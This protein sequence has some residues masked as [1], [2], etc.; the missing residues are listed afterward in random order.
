MDDHGARELVV[1]ALVGGRQENRHIRS[2]EQE[3][4]HEAQRPKEGKEGGQAKD[5]CAHK[6]TSKREGLARRGIDHP[7][8]HDVVAQGA[9][10]VTR[11]APK[12]RDHSYTD[13][14]PHHHQD[15]V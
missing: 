12:I 13:K 7:N 5:D 8:V 4:A 6:G 15:S 1:K 3:R 10:E 2:Q 11:Q 14:R 9:P